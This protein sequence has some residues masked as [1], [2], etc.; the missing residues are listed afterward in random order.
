MLRRRPKIAEYRAAGIF[1]RPLPFLLLPYPAIPF[2][3]SFLPISSTPL[4]TKKTRVA[5]SETNPLSRAPFTFIIAELV[6][7]TVPRMLTWNS[8]LEGI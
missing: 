5:R 4:P 2:L 3:P 8:S 1:L 7:A 6:R